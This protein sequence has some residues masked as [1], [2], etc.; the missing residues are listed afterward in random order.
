MSLWVY[1]LVEL[2][3]GRKFI[4]GHESAALEYDELLAD[5]L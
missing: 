2:S 5:S 4:Q 3:V 1:C